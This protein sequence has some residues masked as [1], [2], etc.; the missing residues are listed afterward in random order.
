MNRT[1]G[2]QGNVTVDVNLGEE[3]IHA[4][5][6]LENGTVHGILTT[7]NQND[8]MKLR[9]VAD[10]FRSIAAG[11]WRVGN[12]SVAAAGDAGQEPAATA[13]ERTESSELY[14][15]AKVFLQSVQQGSVSRRVLSGF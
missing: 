11:S 13:G 9:R 3:R 6:R 8:V 4:D 12:V 2:N 7:E 10:N 14:R 1:G 5:L 15:V